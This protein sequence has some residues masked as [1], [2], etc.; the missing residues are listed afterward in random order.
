MLGVKDTSQRCSSEII[1]VPDFQAIAR[2]L[3]ELLRSS[4]E[5]PKS[6][7]SSVIGISRP[8]RRRF[9]GIFTE[10]WARAL[11]FLL[12]EVGGQ[13]SIAAVRFADKVAPKCRSETGR[14]YFR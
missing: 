6:G 12:N 2:M 8:S 13:R 7:S 5:A 1:G 11:S 9:H 4:A 14:S 10:L 3:D